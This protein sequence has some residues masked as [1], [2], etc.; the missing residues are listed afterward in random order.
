MRR[1]LL[2]T[3]LLVVFTT[4]G[5]ASEPQEVR[6]W[7]NGA[8]GSEGKSA[9]ETLVIRPD[10][11]R[12]VATVHNPS[13]T[14]YLP[15]KASAT[16]AAAIVMPGG[17]HQYLSIENE[18]HSVAQWLS[19]HGIAGFVLKYRL[20][21]EE[22]STYTIEQHALQDAQRAIRLVR[23]RAKEWNVDPERVG[24]MGFSAGGQLAYLAATR[25]DSGN[26]E[27]TDLVERES[28]RPAY[29]ALI[30][31]GSVDAAA[32]LA[33]ETPPTFLCA[34]LDDKGPARTSVEVFQKLRDAGVSAELHVYA[35]GGHGF[36]MKNRPLPIT[37]WPARF[38]EWMGDRG[39]LSRASSSR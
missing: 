34:A 19:E 6:L 39:F 29:Q 18:G 36:G 30:Y 12:R 3:S 13:I 14:L 17:G 4:V 11:M 31:S 26:S 8:P 1:M 16:G 21:R 9:P 35:A 27:S 23:S 38:H 10:G 22:G 25:S 7:P 24:V 5:T 20:A 15:S 33:A 37:A 2:F 28:S 32:Q